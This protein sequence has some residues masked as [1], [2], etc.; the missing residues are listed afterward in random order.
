MTRNI[1]VV[2]TADWRPPLLVLSFANATNY[3]TTVFGLLRVI[4]SD[5]TRETRT[6]YC[7]RRVGWDASGFRD[8]AEYSD[9]LETC[10]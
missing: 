3:F 4:V 7:G 1:I 2:D 5:R 10:A 6:P 8:R 9:T